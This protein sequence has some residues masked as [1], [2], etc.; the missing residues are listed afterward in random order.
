MSDLKSLAISLIPSTPVILQAV[1]SPT[2]ISI[3]K[4]IAVPLCFFVVSKTVDVAIQLYVK[5]WLERRW[6]R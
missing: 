1:E 5:P 4:S 3:A 6:N 2:S